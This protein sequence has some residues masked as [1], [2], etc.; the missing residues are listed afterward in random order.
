[1]LEIEAV[2]AEQLAVVGGIDDERLVP[3]TKVA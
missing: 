3:Q 2:I 1:M